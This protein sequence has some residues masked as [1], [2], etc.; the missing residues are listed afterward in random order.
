MYRARVMVQY[1]SIIKV[2]THKVHSFRAPYLCPN[3][4]KFGTRDVGRCG[5]KD[6]LVSLTTAE[7]SYITIDYTH[8]GGQ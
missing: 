2:G 1:R 4:L 6:K 7:I 5:K 3:I 8:L